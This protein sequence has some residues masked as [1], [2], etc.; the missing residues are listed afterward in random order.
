[1]PSD[2]EEK[3]PER[4]NSNY[5]SNSNYN[6]NSNITLQ[7]HL[8]EEIGASFLDPHSDVSKRLEQ[9]QKLAPFLEEID[10]Y[11][12]FASHDRDFDAKQKQKQNANANELQL[13][14]QFQFITQGRLPALDWK[15]H[16]RKSYT[17]LLWVRPRIGTETEET[18]TVA[19]DNAFGT[20]QRG[21]RLLYRFGDDEDDKECTTGV[22]V[23]VGEWRGPR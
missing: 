5:N 12:S 22:A 6:C 13:Q 17:I 1:M 10:G 23:S 16:F 7:E 9:A 15:S 20:N 19:Q 14:L 21:K 2:S 11:W 8:A 3:S 4:C 18:T